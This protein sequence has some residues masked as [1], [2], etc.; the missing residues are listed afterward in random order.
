MAR[1]AVDTKKKL[2]LIT[3]RYTASTNKGESVKGT[4]KAISE[5]EAERLIIIRGLNPEHVEVAPS[6]FSLAE[7]FPSL[8]QV[9]PREV[10]IFSRQLATLIKSGISLLPALE[11][12]SEQMES[13]VFLPVFYIP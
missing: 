3:Y 5:I 12:L 7:A 2:Q 6:M 11:I 9:K 8:F 1:A 13:V 4:I 10:I